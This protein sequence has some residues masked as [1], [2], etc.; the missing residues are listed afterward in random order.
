MSIND[1]VQ[2]LMT[3]KMMIC[4]KKKKINGGLSIGKRVSEHKQ[5][6]LLAWELVVLLCAI[7]R[8]ERGLEDGEEVSSCNGT[9]CG[10]M[11][12]DVL[13]SIIS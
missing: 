8:K 7:I 6:Q 4:G 10:L 3:A 9:C 2:I 12:D 13:Y 5:E 1:Q 11:A